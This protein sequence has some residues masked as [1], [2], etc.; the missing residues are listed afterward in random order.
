MPSESKGELIMEKV[1]VLIKALEPE[2]DKKCIQIKQ[3]E[4]RQTA[5]GDFYGNFCC[6]AV[7]SAALVFFGISLYTVFIPIAFAAAVLLL[8]SPVLVRKGAESYEQI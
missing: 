8:A 7:C 2:I 4:E 3:K 6:A 1:D 5:D